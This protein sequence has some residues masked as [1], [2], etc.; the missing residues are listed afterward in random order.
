MTT[1]G[2]PEEFPLV[3][4]ELIEALERVFPMVDWTVK[5]ELKDVLHYAGQRYVVSFLRSH[6]DAQHAAP[7][8]E[9]T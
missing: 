2:S 5:A 4:T 3:P 6:H 9:E 7:D 8:A 1:S